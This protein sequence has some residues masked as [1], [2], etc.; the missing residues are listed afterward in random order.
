MKR[1]PFVNEQDIQSTELL[2]AIKARRG[3]T[4][5][6]L[7][8]MLLHS[9]E[10]AAGWNTF[11]GKVRN[12]LSISPKLAELAICYVAILN[13]ASYELEQHSPIF[14][15]AGGTQAQLNALRAGR[16]DEAVFDRSEAAVIALTREMTV[17]VQVSDETINLLQKLLGSEQKV[18]EIIGVVA[19]YNMVSRFL[20]ALEIKS[21]I[22][23]T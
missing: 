23:D 8:Q 21:E 18:V 17:N 4:L 13:E 2:A 10:Y 7:D 12:G 22:N 16:F 19:A 11:L 1:I 6:K 9:P 3:G 15:A 20:V 5:L 14:F